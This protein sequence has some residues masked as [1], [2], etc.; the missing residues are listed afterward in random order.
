MQNLSYLIN[1]SHFQ[2]FVI[3]SKQQNK[4]DKLLFWSLITIFF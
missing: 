2:L 1:I 4:S 3:Q